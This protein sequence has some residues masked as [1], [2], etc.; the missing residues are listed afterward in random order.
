[1]KSTSL[2]AMSAALALGCGAGEPTPTV[3]DGDPSHSRNG[4]R[5]KA[6]V[7]SGEDGSRQ[8][9]GWSDSL[10]QESCSFVSTEQGMRCLPAAA[11]GFW[12]YSDSNCRNAVLSFQAPGCATAYVVMSAEATSS[13]GSSKITKLF[14]PGNS[15]AKPQYMR[16]DTG[17]CQQYTY[18]MADR[19]YSTWTEISLTDF[20]GSSEATIP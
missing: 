10:R 1:M 9:L 18:T 3:T 13:C 6:R 15:T 20:V 4:T 14:S 7:L 2:L 8:F 5:L 16:S 12:L 11:E 17:S 19:F